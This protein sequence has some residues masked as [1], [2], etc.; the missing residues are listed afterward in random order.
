M[1]SN[2]SEALSERLSI[3]EN[4]KWLVCLF[5]SNLHH[6]KTGAHLSNLEPYCPHQIYRQRNLGGVMPNFLGNGTLV[7]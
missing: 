1:S 2:L 7:P 5:A 6:K 4:Q 3:K